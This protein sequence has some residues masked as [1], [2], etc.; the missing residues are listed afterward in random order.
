[1]ASNLQGLSDRLQTDPNNG[2]DPVIE[3]LDEMT[4]LG[5]DIKKL[6]SS[7]GAGKGK[8]PQLNKIKDST[9]PLSITRVDGES[10]GK[11]LS[12]ATD[13]LSKDLEKFSEAEHKM[14]TD[15]V[16]EIGK[17]TEKNL[18][19]FNKGIKE[20]VDLAKKGQA[21]AEKSGNI[22]GAKRFGDTAK[23]AK[24]EHF[25]VNKMDLRGDKD[26]FANRF[27]RALGNK[28]PIDTKKTGVRAFGTA[29]RQGAKGAMK[30]FSRGVLKGKEGSFRDQIF[31]SDKAKRSAERE[32]Q[33][34]APEAE[35][36]IDLT[37]DQKK[38]LAQKGIA[39]ASEKDISYRKAGKPV[40]LK[41][42]NAEIEKDYE[43]R[44]NKT[45]IVP[46][47][48]TA[49]AEIASPVTDTGSDMQEVSAGLA[50][51]PVVD[52]IEE[53]TE[54]IKGISDT[55]KQTLELIDAINKSMQKIAD[56]MDNLG[57]ES[58]GGDSGGFPSID[59]DLP[60]RKRGGSLDA[61]DNRKQS[62]SDRARSQ[63]RDAKGRFAKRTPDLPA[64]RKPG[65][66]RG[67]LGALAAGAGAIGLGAMVASDDTESSS[68]N[69]ATNA[70]MTAT[71]LVDAGGSGAKN[72][73]KATEKGATKAGEK[74]AAKV[75][76]KTAV[77]AG[78][79][80]AAKGVAKVGAKAVGKS[81]LKKIPGVS[82]LAGGAFAA[83]RAMQGDFLGAGG[84]LL[85]GV[86]GS[87]PGIGTAA[88][89]G[90]DAALAARDMGALGGVPGQAEQGAAGAAKPAAKPAAVQG[91]PG[92]GIFSRAAGFVK[93]N[94]LMAAAGL[95]GVGLAAVGASKAWDWMS[96]GDE[97]K[98]ESGQNPDSGILEQGTEK[99]KDQMKVNVPPPTIINQGGG[100]GAKQESTTVPN[101][102][103]YVRDDE[104]SWMR[105]AL[106][107]AM[108]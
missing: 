85:S 13:N 67:I 55:S 72:E 37:E 16:T 92:G 20:V 31:T 58:G 28:E 33:G 79:K 108:A 107:R 105:F 73:A 103:S 29:L 35:K 24:D 1:M 22:E 80:V 36:M 83:Q 71:D 104:S 49:A 63:S 6:L 57:G 106:K 64:G 3:R 84:E 21:L 77:K 102:K 87:I 101:T 30:E 68:A 18:E 82:I 12:A 8:E 10:A 91:K 34:W 65:K 9:S 39:P 42:I 78:E 11:I 94:P 100:G 40:S 70:A 86:A 32:K 14:M 47:K 74:T 89:V 25:R 17:L 98:V 75:G 96:G 43:D 53:Q 5:R 69:V 45:A 2:R 56:S 26:T 46:D 27:S 59:I 44:N 54:V 15:L 4:E 76:E 66:G 99:A 62:K 95:G 19:G 52:A 88:S 81:L 7:T 60:S 50:D 23:A 38:M 93:K 90:I 61:S 51:S 41:D 48:T 97:K